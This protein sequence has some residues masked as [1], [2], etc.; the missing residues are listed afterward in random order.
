MTVELES[1]LD[2]V[3][4]KVRARAGAGADQLRGEQDGAVKVAVT[5]AAEK[6]K[7]NKAI[8]ALLAKRLGLRK[9]QLE[10]VSGHTSAQKLV[11]VRDITA[12][13]LAPRIVAALEKGT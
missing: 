10:I 3:V 7:A 5:Q 13:D 11:L 6:G 8:L 2:G 9:S 12:T 4:F 1:R